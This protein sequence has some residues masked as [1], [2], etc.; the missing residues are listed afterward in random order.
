MESPSGV[1]A[2]FG[3]TPEGRAWLGRLERLRDE[4]AELWVLELGHW[5]AGSNVS[6]VFPA[7]REDGEL[8]A[9]KI[10]F[11]EG[12]SEHEA[13]AL[14]HW[15]GEGAARLLEHDR[16]RRALLVERCEP[17]TTLWELPD[18]QEANRIAIGVFQRIWRAPP[19]GHPFGLLATEAARWAEELP[20][21]WIGLGK[22]FERELLDRA[23]TALRELGPNQG[24][25][26]VLHQ[27]FHGGNVLLSGRGWLAIDPKPLVGEREFDLASLLRD[28]REE[29]MRDPGAARRIR[30]RLDQLSSELALDRDRM[31][32][33]AVAHALAWGVE[34]DRVYDEHI[35]CARWLAEA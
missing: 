24:E 16:E 35:A 30:R 20:R 11:P 26:V 34:E 31:K 19:P 17:G 3:G 33:W 23:V 10:N 28:R 22:P 21:R 9:L 8:A 32:G 27:D 13:D 2:T 14:A 29:L 6:V 5:F 7:V 1:V 25:P 12:E 4:C 18:E 15:A